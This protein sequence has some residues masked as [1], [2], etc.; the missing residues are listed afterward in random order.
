MT[1]LKAPEPAVVRAPSHVSPQRPRQGWFLQHSPSDPGWQPRQ[2]RPRRMLAPAIVAS[3]GL[4]AGV[5]LH[6]VDP[7][8]PGNYPTCPLLA[9]TGLYCPG[10]GAMRASASLTDGDIGAAMSFN[11]LAVLAI[12]ALTVIFVR[13]T[14]RMW[15][16]R[17]K[18]TITRPWV[19]T[20]LLV[21]VLTFWVARN[22]AGWTLLSPA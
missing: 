21:L 14:V 22:I 10:C 15:T 2:S 8:E 4:A 13:W 1:S 6:L 17:P 12:A 19:T 3:A 11:P 5:L 9:A 18:L 7:R 16:G 20:A